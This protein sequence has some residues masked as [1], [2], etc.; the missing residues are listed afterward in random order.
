MQWYVWVGAYITTIAVNL[1]EPAWQSIMFMLPKTGCVVPA[2][3]GHTSRKRS[4]MGW[5]EYRLLNECGSLLPLCAAVIYVDHAL[6]QRPL[7]VQVT[8]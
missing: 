2:H 5:A 3:R 7:F 1:F 6:E 8:Q 4:H